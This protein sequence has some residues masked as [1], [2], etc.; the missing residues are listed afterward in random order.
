MSHLVMLAPANFGSALAQL[1]AGRLSR[2]KTWFQG[3]EPGTGV[4]DWLELGSRGSWNQ[5]VDWIRSGGDRIGGN[6]VFPFVLT[7]QSIDRKLYDN[8]NSYTG[9]MGSD[10]VVRVAAANLNAVW[11]RLVQQR[12]PG[13]A[14]RRRVWPLAPDD[15]G[16]ERAPA[17]A[18]RIVKGRSHSGDK[19]G[20]IRSVRD[21]GAP[22]P[23]VDA[24]LRCLLVRTK[25][26]YDRLVAEFAQETVRVVEDEREE[27]VG[28]RVF[29][30]DP[31][32]MVTF[33][34]RDDGGHPVTDYDLILTGVNDSPNALPPGFFLD[35]QR[36]RRD[37]SVIT[38]FFNHDRMARAGRLGLRVE[39]RPDSGFVHYVKA[40]LA[41]D[42]KM[43][44]TIVRDHETT[45]VEIVL[46]R[47]VRR[48]VFELTKNPGPESFTDQRKGPPVD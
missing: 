37:R 22:H 1:G 16:I 20:I 14:G 8:L 25:P 48:G 26:Q 36:N 15:G 32:S 34:V 43:L 7:G 31:C 27:P 45:L 11:V 46:R 24:T 35:R 21:D 10:G 2:I 41:A 5:N 30:H 9:E 39:A 12:E 6:G 38:Y 3:V 33:R 23:T 19:M 40:R 4:L 17:T 18:M 47:V 13:P 44:E 42:A 28:R 29:P